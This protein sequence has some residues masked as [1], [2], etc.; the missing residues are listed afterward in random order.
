MGEKKTILMID[1]M[2]FNHKMASDLLA[3]EYN[4]KQA[5]SAAE[6]FDILK[7]NLPDLIL[8]DIVMPEMDGFEMLKILKDTPAYRNIPVI[9]LT[10]DT[11]PEDEVEG[12]NNGIVDYITK[13]F[14]PQVMKR[15]IQTQLELSEYRLDLEKK[16]DEKVVEIEAMYDLITVSFAGL[17]ESRDGVTGGH[18]KNTSVYYRAFIEHLAKTD[19]YKA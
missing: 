9:F 5:Y 2:A 6:G 17:V 15:R 12:F 1:D 19:R 18:L 8:L 14:I 10:S 13:P 11:K 4:L 7:E 3:E 16:V